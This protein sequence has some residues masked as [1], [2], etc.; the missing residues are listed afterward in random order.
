MRKVR[1]LTLANVDVLILSN[2]SAA[3]APFDGFLCPTSP[4]FFRSLDFQLPTFHHDGEYIW[5]AECH[6]AVVL[7]IIVLLEVSIRRLAKASSFPTIAFWEAYRFL[8]FLVELH[9]D[10]S[11]AC[12]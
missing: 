5:L 2:L 3:R 9:R 1:P 7:Q 11:T 10:L 6:C 12:L 4:Q 8:D